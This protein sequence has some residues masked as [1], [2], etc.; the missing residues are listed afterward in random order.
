DQDDVSFIAMEFVEGK[1]LSAIIKEHTR[2]HFHQ[3][4]DIAAQIASA[5]SYSHDHGIIHRDIKPG[6]IM[7]DKTGVV[8][9]TDFGLARLQEAESITKAGHTVGSPLYMSP[10]QIQSGDIDYRSD[11]FSL[12]VVYYEMLTGVRPFEGESMSQVIEKITELEPPFATTITEDLPPRVDTI[13]RKMMAKSP[14]DRYQTAGAAGRDL[15][16]LLSLPDPFKSMTESDAQLTTHYPGDLTPLTPFKKRVREKQP[17]V[18]K[19][20]LAMILGAIFGLMGILH[21]GGGSEGALRARDAI[22]RT[23]EWTMGAGSPGP[24]PTPAPIPAPSPAPPP[25]PT[26]P[27]EAPEP[28]AP[29]QPEYGDVSIVSAVGGDVFLDGEKIGPAPISGFQV[30]PGDHVLELRAE[31]YQSWSRNIAVTGGARLDFEAAPALAEG[32][33]LAESDPAGAEVFID[34]QSLGVTPVMITGLTPGTRSAR[35]ELEGYLP[36]N[37]QARMAEGK[38]AKISAIMALAAKLKVAAPDGALVKIG[39]KEAGHGKVEATLA[40]GTHVVE[41][42]LAGYLRREQK[43]ELK[44]GQSLELEISLESAGYGSLKI[45][46]T[47]WAEIYI[48]GVRTGATPRTVPKIQAGVV[49]VKLVNPGYNPFVIKVRVSPE[50]QARVTHTFRPEEAVSPSTGGNER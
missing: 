9:I 41:V 1:D 43:V 49:E 21:A 24:N 48:N 8:K 13:L 28:P 44:P 4:T 45:T 6:N 31:G 20:G 36:W 14:R 29:P 47:P 46:A 15:K 50:K 19:L 5:L 39:G 37:G 23:I 40:P 18:T 35:M 17:S 2:L 42:S 22:N 25:E 12:G 33:L 26:P 10:E 38:G 34:G 16:N 27:P 32:S 7:L 3:A 30:A 11:I